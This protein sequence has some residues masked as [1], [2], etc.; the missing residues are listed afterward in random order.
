MLEQLL[1]QDFALSEKNTLTFSSG[2]TSITGETGA[3]KSLT[4]DALDLVLGG[5]ASADLVRHG[6]REAQ[7]EAIFS[8]DEH[9][10][11]VSYLK[12]QALAGDDNQVLLR[13]IISAD[14]KSK[15]YV[16]NHPCTLSVLR[17]LGPKL[18]SI[19]GQHASIKLTD[20]S[21]QL[22]L[23]DAYADLEELAQRV[24]A[25]YSDYY[26]S[27]SKLS[28]LSS[29]QQAGANEY[30]TL[31]YELEE[32][33][34]L[35]LS[36]GDYEQLS[37]E[38]DAL[39][40]ASLTETAVGLALSMLDSD[41]H[42]LMEIV[43][44]RLNDLEKVRKYDEERI[45]RVIDS[46]KE[47]LKN[48][49]EARLS[50]A[51]INSA[52]DP[53]RVLELEKQLTLCHNLAR[54]F[55]VKP[56][57]LYTVQEQLTQKLEH[58]LSLKDEIEALTA[59]V[60]TKRQAYEAEAQKLSEARSKAA[61]RMSAEVTGTIVDLAMPDGN[62]KVQCTRDNEMKPRAEGRDLVEFLFT[63]NRGE[64]LKALG[65]VASGGELSRLALAIEVLTASRNETQTLIFDEVDTGISG[66]TA[67][68]V[69]KLLR[70]LG[71]LVQV[72]TVT[73]LPQ[74]A[75]AAQQQFLVSKDNAL[76]K[77]VSSV[78]ELSF[79]ERV[80]EISRMMGGQVVTEATYASARAL[81]EAYD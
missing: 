58:F 48:L 26:A 61:E 67:S 47:G 66:R 73:H 22:K 3:G 40:H 72:I 34:K 12:E 81:L 19:H 16:N 21:Y 79:E 43:Q 30:K 68:S 53:K 56:Q 45:G 46:L 10:E 78:K 70:R 50:L 18:V 15:A 31:K 13:R 23:L 7:L 59:Q 39:Q 11:L 27:R 49:D 14:G 32:L 69:G 74:V 9:S 20:S 42:N 71:A 24:R 41:E 35:A 54:R 76:D 1:V 4:V 75:A 51:E 62:F 2:M 63:A 28:S 44:A 25:L 52:A 33:E 80:E 36:A 6:A 55:E 8:I 29:E 5:R 38:Y 60:R 17:E 37:A 57:E 65:A 64:P 77:A